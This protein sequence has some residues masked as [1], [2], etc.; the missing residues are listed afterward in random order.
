MNNKPILYSYFQKTADVLLAE[1]N[2]SKEQNASDNIGKNREY[3]C[4]DFLKKVLPTKLS[5]VSG[6]IW[7]SK[8]NRTG[9]LDVLIIRDDAPSLNIGSDNIYLAEG[10]F[11]VIEVKSNLTREKLVEAKE[12]LTKVV[13][14]EVTKSSTQIFITP[15]LDRPLRVVFAYEGATWDTIKDEINKNN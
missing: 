3:F 10:V 2:R 7:D 11:S 13:N 9:Q 4:R 8:N 5:T 12:T 14:L 15:I 1:Y 6:E